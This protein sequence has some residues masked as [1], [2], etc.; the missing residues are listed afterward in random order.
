[1]HCLRCGICCT[2]TEM[3]LSKKDIKRLEKKDYTRN[4]F[5]HFDNEGYARLRN[6]HG[7][8]VFY[9]PEKK[10]CKVRSHRPLGCR[11]YPVIYHETK[12]ITIDNICPN[13]KKVAEKEKAKKGKRVLQ[14]LKTIDA[15]AEQRRKSRE[16]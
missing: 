6:R 3:L 7:Y 9:D 15:E 2:E 12:G 16:V 13:H 11:I 8:C 14:L 4:F 1:M 5:V 10:D